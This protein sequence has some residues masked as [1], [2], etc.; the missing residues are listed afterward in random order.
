MLQ[1]TAR[2]D[3]FHHFPT[4]FVC[5]PP[6]LGVS[7]FGLWNSLLPDRLLIQ[8]DITDL[9]MGVVHQ[10]GYPNSWLVYKGKS[11]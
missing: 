8:K 9:Q 3:I 11:H 10:W 6:V 5:S 4:T 2:S 7:I 1:V